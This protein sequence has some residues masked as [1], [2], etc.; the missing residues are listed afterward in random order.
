MDNQLINT[1]NVLSFEQKLMSIHKL[2]NYTILNETEPHLQVNLGAILEVINSH[3]QSQS[4]ETHYVY[5]H[6]NNASKASH[7]TFMNSYSSNI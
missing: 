4:H 1:G 2:N 3:L 6:D 7:V 5:E